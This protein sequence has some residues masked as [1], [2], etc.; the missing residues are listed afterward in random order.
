[1]SNDEKTTQSIDWIK[2]MQQ[3]DEGQL[4]FPM[5]DDYRRCKELHEDSTTELS[6]RSGGKE[7]ENEGMVSLTFKFASVEDMMSFQ[8]EF[9]RH[10]GICDRDLV[11]D[12]V[13]FNRQFVARMDVP[14][15]LRVTCHETTMQP[16]C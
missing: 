9:I 12:S 13:Y 7:I 14:E 3:K 8:V 10:V 1:M 4:T 11:D 6:F 5:D 16:H 2:K 15:E